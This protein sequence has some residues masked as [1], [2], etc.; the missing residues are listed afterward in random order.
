MRT[1]KSASLWG[2]WKSTCQYLLASTTLPT[3]LW[4]S[5]PAYVNIR[6]YGLKASRTEMNTE[7]LQLL[8]RIMEG[9]YGHLIPPYIAP[10]KSM[11]KFSLHSS[12]V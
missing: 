8:G 12:Y 11:E 7:S 10:I 1:W 6:A 9:E 2:L 5:V 4:S 3:F